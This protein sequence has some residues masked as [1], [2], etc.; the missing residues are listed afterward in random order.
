MFGLFNTKKINAVTG[1]TNQCVGGQSVL[2]K[3]FSNAFRS[4]Q[5]EIRKIELTYF[6]LSLL[7]YIFLR[8]SNLEKKEDIL[9]EVSSFVLNK[10]LPSCGEGLSKNQAIGEYHNRYREYNEL[11]RP[12]FRKDGNINEDACTQL[13]MHLYEVVMRKSAQGSMVMLLASQP[14][15]EQYVLDNIDF[16]K[17]KFKN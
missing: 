4:E 3:I 11:L 12:F 6:S 14:L 9:D 8:M 5:G 10:S 7:V 15:F 17:T 13:F 1:L 16:V 2:F